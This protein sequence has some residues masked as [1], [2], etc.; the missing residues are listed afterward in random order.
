M[1]K[2]KRY[3][4]GLILLLAII[5][6]LSETFYKRFDMTQDKRYTLTET[7][8]EI[9]KRVDQ[10]LNFKILLGGELPG[11]YRTLKNE[12]SFMLDEFRN[13]NPKISFQFSDPTKDFTSDQLQEEGLTLSLIHI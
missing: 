7:T 2:T 13:I 4:I 5:V 8:K 3:L 11:D 9:L 6:G 1:K 10:P 12:I